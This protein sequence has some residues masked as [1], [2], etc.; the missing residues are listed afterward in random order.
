MVLAVSIGSSLTGCAGGLLQEPI[1]GIKNHLLAQQAWTDYGRPT[2][3][4]AAAKFPPDFERG[5]KKGFLNVASGRDGKLPIVPERRYWGAEYQTAEG[6]ARVDAWYAGFAQG[7]NAALRGDVGYQS[8]I[9]TSIVGTYP[10]PAVDN[11]PWPLQV[12]AVEPFREPN[13]ESYPLPAPSTAGIAPNSPSRNAAGRGRLESDHSRLARKPAPLT[14][15]RLKRPA[16]SA[17]NAS[18]SDAET[19]RNPSSGETYRVSK[20]ESLSKTNSPTRQLSRGVSSSLEGLF[21]EADADRG[22]GLR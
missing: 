4:Q 3:S 21:A 22:D 15:V 8:L 12:P 10:L 18:R 6:Q 1:V 17:S 2:G 7:S 11:H 14:K 13:T 16:D 5:W 9:P 19:E 20:A